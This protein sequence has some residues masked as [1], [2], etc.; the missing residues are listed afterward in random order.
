MEVIRLHQQE[1]QT[2]A[3]ESI[4]SCDYTNFVLFIVE[5]LS[6]YT[7]YKQKVKKIVRQLRQKKKFFLAPQE[8]KFLFFILY[9][10]LN[11]FD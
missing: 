4:A 2:V 8:A 11:Q 6:R 9:Y 1:F 7:I 3:A 10:N 5:K